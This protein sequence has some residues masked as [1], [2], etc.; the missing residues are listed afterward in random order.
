MSR[1]RSFGKTGT[2]RLTSLD[3]RRCLRRDADLLD[4]EGR[5][6]PGWERLQVSPSAAGAAASRAGSGAVAACWSRG[7]CLEVAAAR[8]AFSART[9]EPTA[10]CGRTEGDPEWLVTR[11][12]AYRNSP[13]CIGRIHTCTEVA[14]GVAG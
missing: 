2:A 14:E 13:Q 9:K 12:G 8:P 5:W 10:A 3:R 11:K 4:G 6:K 7:P 1:C